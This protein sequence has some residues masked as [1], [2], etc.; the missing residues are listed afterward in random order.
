MHKETFCCTYNLHTKLLTV[1][2][3]AEWCKKTYVE[4]KI[5]Q[6]R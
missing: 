4:K 5:H 2:E 1:F 6:P 3:G